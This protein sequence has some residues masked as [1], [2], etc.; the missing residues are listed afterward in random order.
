MKKGDINLLSVGLRNIY[1]SRS[2]LGSA[3]NFYENLSPEGL[4]KVIK[5]R[6]SYSRFS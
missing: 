3:D 2:P 1:V 5:K 6:K 4:M